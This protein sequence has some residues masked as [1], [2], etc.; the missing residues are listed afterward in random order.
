MTDAICDV[1]TSK[2]GRGMQNLGRK[3]G[4]SVNPSVY[5]SLWIMTLVGNAG[6]GLHSTID[7]SC[8]CHAVT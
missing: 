5:D 3:N 1:S 2:L 7:E 8:D 6:A 4:L